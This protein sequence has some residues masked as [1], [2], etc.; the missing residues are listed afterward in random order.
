MSVTHNL[1]ADVNFARCILVMQAFRPGKLLF[2]GP[3]QDY[4]IQS[5]PAADCFEQLHLQVQLQVQPFKTVCGRLTPDGCP[6]LE[7]QIRETGD[8]L[9]SGLPIG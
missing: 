6:C 2:G 3:T 5:E 7:I 4:T 1:L 9:Q 8:Y